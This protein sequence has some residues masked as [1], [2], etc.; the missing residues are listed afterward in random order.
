L[1]KKKDISEK[2][3][4]SRTYHYQLRVLI[5]FRKKKS[6]NI[7]IIALNTHLAKSVKRDLDSETF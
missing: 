4:V 5:C 3:L 2:A 7:V 1:K 6:I